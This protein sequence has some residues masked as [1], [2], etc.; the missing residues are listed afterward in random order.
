MDLYDK[1]INI[2]TSLIIATP[3]IFICLVSFII[4]ELYLNTICK[5]INHY[6]T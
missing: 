4:N 2:A 3:L 1:F 5:P 6:V